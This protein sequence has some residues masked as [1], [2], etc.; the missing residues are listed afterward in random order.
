M[1]IFLL[2]VSLPSNFFLLSVKYFS[3]TKSCIQVGEKRWTY[4]CVLDLMFVKRKQPQLLCLCSRRKRRGRGSG[5]ELLCRIL[6]RNSMGGVKHCLFGRGQCRKKYS[7]TGTRA[8]VA[9]VRAEYPNQ[10]DY[11]GFC[12]GH[13]IAFQNNTGLLPDAMGPLNFDWR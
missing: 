13:D 1:P 12:A 4:A 5:D 9:R 10:L 3:S 2:H 7:A 6:Y 8:R 11:S